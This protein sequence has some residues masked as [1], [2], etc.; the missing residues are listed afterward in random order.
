MFLRTLSGRFLLLTSLFVLLAEAMILLPTVANHRRDYLLTRLEKAQI[1]SLALLNTDGMIEP[2]LE[3]ELLANAGV[4]NVVLR[5]DDQRRL[6]L[7]SP[8]PAPIEA[9]YDL[10]APTDF[11]LVRDALHQLFRPANAVIRVI[12]DPVRAGGQFIEITLET[13]PLRAGMLETGF[14]VL[15]LSAVFSVLTAILL[16]LAVRRLLVKPIQRLVARMSA[17][18]EA[19][20]DARRL[21]APSARI[22]ELREAEEALATM[23]RQM[24]SAL[25]QKERLAQ[26]GQAVAKI[27]H[28][29]RNILTT[30]QL[31]ADRMD[32][33]SDPGVRRA[34]PKLVGSIT[35]AVNLCE[36]TLAFGRAEEPAPTLSRFMIAGLV[37]EVVEAEMLSARAAR[38]DFVTDIAPNLVLRADPEQMYRVISNLVRNACQAIEATGKPGTIEIGAGEEEA[39]WWIRVGDSGPGLPARARE[40]LFQPFQGSVR[41]GG[42][43]L[44][45]TISAE[46]VRGHGG[47]LE[48][49]RSDA[50]GTE[51]LIHLPRELGE[52]AA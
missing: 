28:D 6:V 12:G 14:R 5:R 7:S 45:L 1:A 26:L 29:L 10:R 46:L 19:P 20:E 24:S 17:W 41:K 27:S 51:F 22:T 52:A 18:A 47:Q 25:R 34:A 21:I 8:I 4:F 30:A 31:F 50:Q 13:G 32:E 9:T 2:G 38:V 48:L 37:A 42:T 11:E 49:V 16:F 44:G 33:S 39:G 23:Q 40:H 15:V 35:R 36:T 3:R 43:G